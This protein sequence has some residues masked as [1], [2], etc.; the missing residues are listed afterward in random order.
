MGGAAGRGS[1][2][3]PAEEVKEVSA[4]NAE[5]QGNEQVIHT[6]LLARGRA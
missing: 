2:V 4:Q 6:Y 3:A 1:R 5:H